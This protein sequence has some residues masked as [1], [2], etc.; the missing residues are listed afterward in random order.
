MSEEESN[1]P[2]KDIAIDGTNLYKEEVVTDL[3]MGSIQILRP[4]TASGDP[5][6]SR[7]TLYN[8]QTTLMTHMGSLPLNAK[9]E[10]D[11]L[12]EVVEQFPTAIQEAIDK[13]MAEAEKRQREEASRIVTPGELGGLGGGPVPP[14]GGGGGLIV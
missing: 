13:L 4:V 14:A 3:K 10:A 11:G 6:D 2:L 9:V 8:C 5:D 1:D 12:A 7:P